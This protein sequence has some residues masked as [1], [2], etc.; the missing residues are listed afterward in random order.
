MIKNTNVARVSVT[1][2]NEYTLPDGERV[3]VTGQVGRK[4]R[5]TGVERASKAPM[6][7]STLVAGLFCPSELTPV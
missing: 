1:V 6:R 7:E 5:C 2:G 3:V 4:F